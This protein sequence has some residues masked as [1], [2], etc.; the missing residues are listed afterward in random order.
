MVEDIKYIKKM[1]T[2]NN[3]LDYN[4]KLNETEERRNLLIKEKLGKLDDFKQKEEEVHRKRLHMQ[5]VKKLRLQ[6]YEDK[7][8]IAIQK[9]QDQNN[10]KIRKA[11]I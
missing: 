6:Q 10:E 7:R 2:Y 8:K 5:T 3:Q 4:N 11:N 9:K 1:N